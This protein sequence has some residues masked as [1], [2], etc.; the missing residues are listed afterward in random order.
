M[1]AEALRLNHGIN[2][3]SFKGRYAYLFLRAPGSHSIFTFLI[4]N[5]HR[6]T[7]KKVGIPPGQTVIPA[8]HPSARY[9]VHPFALDT[10]LL[11][12]PSKKWYP[13]KEFISYFG[14]PRAAYDFAFLSPSIRF[15]LRLKTGGYVF[16]I[17]RQREIL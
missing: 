6:M 15:N 11:F 5:I 3:S 8:G 2:K 16:A 1:V 4:I 10:I 12:Y 14:H 17:S 13:I 7:I 9:H